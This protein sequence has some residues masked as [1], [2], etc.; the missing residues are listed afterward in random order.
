MNDEYVIAKYLRLSIE[1][2]K[3]ESLSI[4]NQHLLLDAFIDEL[5]IPNAKV[6]TFVDNGHTGTNMER[7]SVQEMLD[8]VRSGGVNL[9]IIKDFSRFSRNAMDSGYFIEQVFPLYQVRFISV[10]DDFD[11]DDYIGDTGGI[12]VAFKFLM[13]EYYS[14]DLSAKVKSAKRLKM[15]RGENIVARAVY[16][17]YKADSG[18]W[19]PDGN[20]SEVV[21][22]I[23][24]YALDGFS[25]AQIRDKLFAE[26][27]PTPQEYLEIG[28][29]KDITPTF[30]W[31]A[32][33]VTRI[34]TNIQY[35][36]TYVS[37]KQES[38]AIGSSSKDW[39]PK[40]EWIVIPNKHT[41]IIAP[42]VFDRV[43][44]IMKSFLTGEATPKSAKHCQNGFTP[45]E[46]VP[47][48][49][50]YGYK[51]GD[52]GEWV[53]DETAS[54]AVRCIFD[55]SLQGIF[56]S[57]IA[58]TLK[59][60]QFPTPQ[61][62]RRVRN[63]K[64]TT[65][66]CAWRT[67]G[68]RDILRDIQYTGA[69]VCGKFGRK[70]DGSGHFRTHESDWIIMP[71]KIP[72]IVSKDEFQAANE[73]IT[74]HGRK[75]GVPSHLL[76]GNIVKCGCCGHAL[77]Y[78]KISDP[79]YRCYHTSA[80]P[81][82]DCHKLKISAKLL[83]DIVL[84]TIRRKAQ[85]VLDCADLSKLRRKSVDEQK[86][87]NCESAILQNTAERQALYERFILGEISRD[88]YLEI[89]ERCNS[90]LER[91]NQQISAMKSELDAGKI[92]PRSIAV[93]K[94]AASETANNRELVET[95][96]KSVEVYSDKRIDINWKIS[97]FGIVG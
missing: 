97:D 24:G 95:L 45:K 33:A 60:E 44:E 93:A 30:L 8:L 68:V 28:R 64:D 48:V 91:L 17:Y 1:D 58:E 73:F 76:R 50:P 38:K 31:E 80:D 82:A 89:K 78:D 75:R 26:Q 65:P 92:A 6:L 12:D 55:L 19:E 29:G 87:S 72:A 94:A 15:K 61:E 84:S 11:S 57:D 81:N 46:H 27:I 34:L 54:K 74:S 23:Y 69:R 43:Q 35:N 42:D 70:A 20:A 25:P 3:T 36:G 49:L 88:E 90:Q 37:G 96:I 14:A 52:D 16:G 40:S 41:P 53:L 13:H 71:G 86:I 67:K 56:E 32:R 66:V 51:F 4:E 9:I 63:G 7:P 85:L 47:R 18:K 22:K 2:E 5:D 59:A 10:S 21:K 62:H 39:N 83:D 77:C 79:V